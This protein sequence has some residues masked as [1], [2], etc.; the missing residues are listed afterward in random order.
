M[1]DITS[2][3]FIFQQ[4]IR[5]VFSFHPE[6]DWICLYFYPAVTLNADHVKKL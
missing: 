3:V 2:Q 6:F 1:L 4:K 5:K